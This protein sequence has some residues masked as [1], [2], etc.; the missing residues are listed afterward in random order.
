LSYA[1]SVGLRYLRSPKRKTVS[2]ITVIAVAGVALGVGALLAVMSITGGFQDAFRSKILGVNAHVLV[3]KYG[4]D[5]SEYDEVVQHAEELHEVIGAAPFVIHEMMFAKGDRLSN[6]LVKGIDPM[7][8]Q[9]VLDLPAQIVRGSLDGLRLADQG[10]PRREL[11]RAKDPLDPEEDLNTYLFSLWNDPASAKAS[12]PE[13]TKPEG[14]RPGAALPSARVPTP[15]EAEAAASEDVA[16][17]D[18]AAEAALFAAQ[19]QKPDLDKVLPGV[20]VGAT[21]AEN[22]GLELGDVVRIVSPLAGL[23]TTFFGSDTSAPSALDFR[24]T[25]VFQAGFQEYDSRLVY[26]D[27]HQAMRLVDHGDTVTGVELRLTSI[28]DAPRIARQLEADL[29]GGPYNTMDWRELNHNLFTA[30]EVQKVM[31]SLVIATI[32]FVAASTSSQR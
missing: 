9:R 1:L 5:F 13:P 3:L 6:V 25:G 15:E 2:V 26:V 32:I 16:L 28:D 12:V 7:R 14:K 22:L 4:L 20:V 29:G 27:L 30:L 21:L 17:P 8:M 31:L 23:D 19:Q 18:D 11:N 10:P 24:V